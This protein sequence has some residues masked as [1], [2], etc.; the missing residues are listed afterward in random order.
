MRG[1]SL[2]WLEQSF[3]LYPEAALFW[4]EEATLAVTDLH[5]GKPASL[6]ASGVPVPEGADEEDLD[7][8]EKLIE[9]CSPKR[10]LML[11]DL[12]HDRMSL[13]DRMIAQFTEFRQRHAEMEI[14]LVLG[15]H[16]RSANKM[17]ELL[18]LDHVSDQWRCGPLVFRHDPDSASDEEAYLIAGHVHPAVRVREGPFQSRRLSCFHFGPHQALLPA[19]GSMTGT[20]RISAGKEDRVFAIVE[21]EVMEIPWQ[22]VR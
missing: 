20:Y 22:L 13:T 11:G 3:V 5:L 4:R 8:L 9:T 2:P 16:D 1:L 10:L 7:R 12:I 15:N 18:E 6:R 21:G 19:F 17:Q 14:D